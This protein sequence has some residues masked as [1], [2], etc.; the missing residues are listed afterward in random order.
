MSKPL[1]SIII[2]CYNYGE[3]IEDAVRSVRSQSYK[4]IE[5]IIINDGST[6]DSDNTIRSLMKNGKFKY[7]SQENQGIIKTRN[8]GMEVAKGDYVI[9]LDADD[10]LDEHYVDKCV[11]AATDKSAGIVYSQFKLFGREDFTSMHPTHDLEKLKHENYIHASALV[12]RS[13]L[14]K[15][16]YDQYLNDKGN[17]DWDL[18][19]GLCLSGASAVLVNEPLLHYRKH[20][21]RNSR[22]DDFEGL[23]NEML[24]RH[25][26]WSKYNEIFPDEFWYFSSQIRA[27]L[28]MINLYTAHL[29]QGDQLAK[30]KMEILALKA[31]VDRLEKRDLVTIFKNINKR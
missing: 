19:L 5:M 24:V 29:S 20:E 7:I 4:N 1:V 26:V 25:H 30:K 22:S 27:L 16:P 8:L 6:D 15:D 23:F 12:K 14:K 3:Y 18:F 17:E 2:T 9:Q 10:Y 21:N 28:E 13:L 11:K 31:R